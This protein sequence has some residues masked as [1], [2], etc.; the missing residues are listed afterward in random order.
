MECH[1][2]KKLQFIMLSLLLAS[3]TFAL[4]ASCSGNCQN[5]YGEKTWSG[6]AT[7][8][9]EWKGGKKHGYGEEK[10][11]YG[12]QYIGYYQNNQFHGQGTFT[13]Y[14]GRRYQGQWQYGKRHGEG[15]VYAA[16]GS[17][18]QTGC[19]EAA[20][21]IGPFCDKAVSKPMIEWF[22]PIS[23]GLETASASATVVACINGAR[24]RQVQFYLN[25][26]PVYDRGIAVI[27]NQCDVKL[28]KTVRLKHGHN[29]LKIVASNAAGQSQSSQRSIWYQTSQ[30]SWDVHDST[31]SEKRTALVIGISDYPSAPLRNPLN[32]ARAMT[33][34]LQD[35][36]FEVISHTNSDQK[37][38]KKAIKRFGDKLSEKGGVGLFY[39]A[40][41]GMQMNGKN[42]L[43]PR[44]AHI[45]K[46]QD[47]ELES[48]DL[49]RLMGEMEYADNRLNIVILDAC[50][51]DPFS[52][53]FRKYRSWGQQSRGLAP[54][55]APSGTF[56]AFA[57]APGSV[58]ADG[59]GSN[60]LYTQELINAIKI[61]GQTIEKVFKIVRRNVREK[62]HGQQKT[63]DNSSIEG[64]FYFKR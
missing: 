18:L 2:M 46:E 26:E 50:R 35:V 39:F 24:Q 25:N 59:E 47:V 33:Q 38:M 13:W 61:P 51:N 31:V 12:D 1:Q 30:S 14:D 55:N 40:G 57:T 58:A 53:R 36:G 42:Y 54:P 9:G 10:W 17:E 27:S 29:R 8:A 62:S 60:G 20:Q 15:T 48:V 3:N 11:N 56:I 5:G 41:H 49:D 19:W 16:D 28:N 63:W 45:R 23:D 52:R 44:D 4:A 64:E 21:Y 32:D 22:N 7:Y 6:R 43:I 34:V 37:E